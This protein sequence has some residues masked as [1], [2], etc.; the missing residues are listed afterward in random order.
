MV[1]P[2]ESREL[3]AA[4]RAL[5]GNEVTAGWRTIQIGSME[6]CLRAGRHFPDGAEALLIGF[7]DVTVAPLQSLP[8][9]R[10]FYVTSVDLG[11]SGQGRTWFSLTREPGASPELFTVMAE[12]VVAEV[13]HRFS[14]PDQNAYRLFL[15]RINAWQS[16]MQRERYN[17]LTAEKEIGLAGELSM[18][19]AII[20]SEVAPM[21]AVESWQGPIEGLQDFIF[22][23]GAIEVKSTVATGT[24]PAKIGSL[25]QLDNSLI[26]PLFLNAVRFAL[27]EAGRTLPEIADAVRQALASEPPAGTLFNTRL[28]YAGLLPSHAEGY[29]RR[30]EH[31]S[32]RIMEVTESFPK[33]TAA[34]VASE[35]REAHYT[36]D[37]D[38]VG[39]PDVHLIHTLREVGAI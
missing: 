17:L 37:L 23:K 34:N 12:D 20:D 36:I 22:A 24:F 27:G 9:G 19:L 14:T 35:V 32:S 25:E 13:Q 30:F 18:L 1:P 29:S 5:Q 7:E 39:E 16:F 26:R 15:D 3:R 38:L 8:K 31:T 21:T 28:I 10:G 33:L 11:P 4:W 2:S 6:Q